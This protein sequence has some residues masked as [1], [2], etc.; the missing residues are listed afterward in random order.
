MVSGKL[1]ISQ[2]LQYIFISLR[3]G[4]PEKDS[5]P[6]L[7]TE[8]GIVTVL[9]A[10][11]WNALDEIAVTVPGIVTEERFVAPRKAALPTLVMPLWITTFLIV[12]TVSF[13]YFFLWETV[14]EKILNSKKAYGRIIALLKMFHL[15]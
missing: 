11:F 3:L 13:S 2:S 5:S 4:Q 7:L 15:L 10:V 14:T 1:T 8:A 12:G 6:I 9:R